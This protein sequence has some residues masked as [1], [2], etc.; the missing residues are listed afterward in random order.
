MSNG[1][2]RFHFD[3]FTSRPLHG[4]WRQPP[5]GS[6]RK[7]SLADGTAIVSLASR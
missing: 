3:R 1:E 7:E 5:L 4:Y 6:E 2:P